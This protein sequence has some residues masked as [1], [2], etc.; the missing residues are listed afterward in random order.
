MWDT[1]QF[2]AP[3]LLHDTVEQIYNILQPGAS[4]L[5][6]FHSDE[7][8]K[9]APIYGYRIAD[10]KTLTLTSRGARRPAQ[11]FNN[12]AL[13]KLFNRFASVKFFLTRDSLREVI[14]RR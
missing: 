4:M 1:L 3:S 9:A 11:F 13:E 12:R 14:V 5:A 10:S 6:F 7:K 2:L 8:V